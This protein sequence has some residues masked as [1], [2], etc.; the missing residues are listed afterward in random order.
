MR[1]VTKI[2]IKGIKEFHKISTLFTHR[3]HLEIVMEDNFIH[4]KNKRCTIS[5]P[6]RFQI[7]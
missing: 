6:K 5:I 2:L 4:Y 7:I 3:S 1:K